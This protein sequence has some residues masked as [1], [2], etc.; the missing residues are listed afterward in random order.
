MDPCIPDN[1]LVLHG[2]FER[3]YGDL[4]EC[5]FQVNEMVNKVDDLSQKLKE[6]E[7]FYTTT[8][9]KEH[10]TSKL[11][12]ILKDKDKD[13]LI[14]NLKKRK[15]DAPLKE[16]AAKKRMLDLMRQFGTII[17]QVTQHKWAI[18][19]MKPVDVVGLG[20]HDYYEIIEKPMDFSTIK[21]RMDCKDGSGY[22]HVRDIWVDVRLIFKNAMK[23]NDEKHDVHEMAKH[24]LS[25]FE[26]KWLNIYPK[27]AEED[28][29][30]EED[31]AEMQFDMRLTH[32]VAHAKMAR[33]LNNELDEVDLHL[34]ELKGLVLEKCRKMTTEEKRRLATHL[35]RL[36]PDDLNEALMIVAEDNPCFQATATEVELDI[37]SQSEL[38]LWRL[39]FFLKDK[40]AT[41]DH[42][43]HNHN[44]GNNANNT[45]S[46]PPATVNKNNN[47]VSKRKREICDAIA[48]NLQKK[49]KESPPQMYNNNPRK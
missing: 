49:A 30:L 17:S 14:A 39:K 6:V 12:S 25:K 31:E 22:K 42:S 3:D 28:K 7:Q 47:N 48:K 33:D 11:G 13:K 35:T 43:N 18:P 4:E 20:L 37:D 8:N 2:N 41:R 36:P 38:T 1:R 46:K 45:N 34:E 44:N 15:H 40:Q 29:R 32:E 5:Q 21:K 26:E 23:Y 19:F 16:A 10:N 24:L 9:K 27:I